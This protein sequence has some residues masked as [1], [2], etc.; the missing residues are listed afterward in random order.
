MTNGRGTLDDHY[1]EWL[2]SQF[3]PVKV[4]NPSRTYWKL[5]KQMYTK[6][7]YWFVPNDDNRVA[8]GKDLRIEFLETTGYILDDPYQLWLELDCS[9][10]EMLIALARRVS[11]ESE[12]DP[13]AWF[14]RLVTNLE[15]E[16]YSDDIYE[17]AVSE[18]VEEALDRINQRTYSSDGVG[19]LFPLRNPTQD[20][21]TV[22]LWYQMSSYLLEG[23]YVNNYP[24]F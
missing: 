16:R 7:F 23:E 17:I 11:F 15:L 5:A 22:E 1:L 13:V 21:R 6:P 4:R 8:D 18:E 9:M 12:E 3:A 19:G 20:Q 24:R 14:W 10:L 2:Y